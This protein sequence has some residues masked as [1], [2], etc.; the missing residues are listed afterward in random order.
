VSQNCIKC[1]PINLEACA[2]EKLF[3]KLP[4]ISFVFTFPKMNFNLCCL[5]FVDINDCKLNP[6]QNGGTCVDKVNSYQCICKEGW[7]G[8]ICSISMYYSVSVCASISICTQ[9]LFH[10]VIHD[11]ATFPESWN[12]KLQSCYMAIYLSTEKLSKWFR[13]NF[14]AKHTLKTAV[15]RGWTNFLRSA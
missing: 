11:I 4:V 10:N 6:C 8:E 1:V 2:V 15:L 9:F 13:T 3:Y 5:S 14:L 12:F 7:E